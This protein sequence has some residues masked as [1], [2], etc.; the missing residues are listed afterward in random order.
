LFP[1]DPFGDAVPRDAHA[2]IAP[3]LLAP[4]LDALLLSRAWSVA[5]T[6]GS[7][8]SA[9]VS[10]VLWRVRWGASIVERG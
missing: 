3:A 10:D 7:T 4:L 8:F 5:G 1:Y 9:Y 6:P 2:P